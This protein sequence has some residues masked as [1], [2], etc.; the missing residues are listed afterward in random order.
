M[1]DVDPPPLKRRDK[2]H[3]AIEA[4]GHDKFIPSMAVH[5]M[6]DQFNC[7]P[8]PEADITETTLTRR[9]FKKECKVYRDSI[10]GAQWVRLPWWL[11]LFH[12]PARN[13]KFI[14]YDSDL[15]PCALST[16]EF[17]VPKAA[18]KPSPIENRK[19]YKGCDIKRGSFNYRA[20]GPRHWLAD[21]LPAGFYCRA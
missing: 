9:V 16:S 21:V 11:S 10:T 19:R 3:L 7:V 1:E 12:N 14:S 2:I 4:F 6:R 18:S 5:R 8:E 17:I 13:Y 15:V 20:H